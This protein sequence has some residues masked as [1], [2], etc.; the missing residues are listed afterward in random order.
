MAI[1]GRLLAELLKSKL[2]FSSQHTK[3][4][5]L[6][7]RRLQAADILEQVSST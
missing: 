6:A 1:G 2:K 4:E 3:K 5:L 7:Q